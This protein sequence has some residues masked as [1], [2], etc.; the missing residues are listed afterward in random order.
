MFGNPLSLLS[1]TLRKPIFNLHKTQKYRSPRQVSSFQ[2][3][4]AQSLPNPT[5]V[6]RHNEIG[7]LRDLSLAIP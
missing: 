4:I 7:K 3:S 2:D 5:S 1:I 6:I